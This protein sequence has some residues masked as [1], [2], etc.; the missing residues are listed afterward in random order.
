MSKYNVRIFICSILS[1]FVILF[2]IVSTYAYFN[3]GKKDSDN[4]NNNIEVT[5]DGTSNLTL[6]NAKSD[7]TL[8]KTWRVKNLTTSTLYLNISLV[9]P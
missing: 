3:N 7:E 1:V 9:R 5:Y 2:M 4:L 8:T 6:V